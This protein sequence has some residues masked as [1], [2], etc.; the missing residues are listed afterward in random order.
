MNRIAFLSADNLEGYVIDDD[1]CYGPLRELGWQPETI[2]WR[3]ADV[4]WTQ[5]VC[6]IIRST[7]DYQRNLPAFLAAMDRIAAAARLANPIDIVRWNA[8]KIYLRDLEKRGARI[9]PTIWKEPGVEPREIADWFREFETNELVIKPTVSAN[10]EN[11][12]RLTKGQT[13]PATSL[14]VFAEQAYMLQPFMPGIAEE[15]EFSLFYLHGNFS[16]AILKTPKP[17]D[18]RVQE[19]HGGIIR[20]VKP[21]PELLA[22]G[23]KVMRLLDETLLYA[24]VDFVRDGDDFALMEL[25]LIEPSLYLR[26]DENAPA[27]FAT[28]INDWLA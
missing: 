13:L 17:H 20:A 8:N 12:V 6:A 3:K 5:F 16:H 26:M 23:E 9:A 22:A 24:R 1:L 18:F 4:D 10:A 2:S 19:E 7:W 27:N 21:T 14:A 25:E 28:A 15:G 11:T